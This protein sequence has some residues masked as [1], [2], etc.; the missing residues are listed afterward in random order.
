M[1]YMP[2]L[3][4]FGGSIFHTWSVWAS[5]SFYKL[6]F[7]SDFG[8]QSDA[9][10]DPIYSEKPTTPVRRMCC[11]HTDRSHTPD[12]AVWITW[13][14]RKATFLYKQVVNST[15]MLVSGLE[16]RVLGDRVGALKSQMPVPC[17]SFR[18]LTVGHRNMFTFDWSVPLGNHST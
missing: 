15:S 18:T 9:T 2:T 8:W 10:G 1:P 3:G 11:F 6:I 13:H 16:C 4:W 12:R 7:Q 5:E 17:Q 14:Q